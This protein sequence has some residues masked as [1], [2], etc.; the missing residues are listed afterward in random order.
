MKKNIL[1]LFAL[2]VLLLTSLACGATTSIASYME[3]GGISFVSPADQA[4]YFFLDD[5]NIP[6]VPVIIRST[7]DRDKD[8]TIFA[9]GTPYTCI[10][11]ANFDTPCGEVPIV[12]GFTTLSAQ[13][14]K[15]DGKTVVS[16]E[17][18]FNWTPPKGIDLAMVWISNQ[19]GAANPSIGYGLV[20]FIILVLS[21]FVFVKSGNWGILVIPF[22]SLVFIAIYGYQTGSVVITL[23]VLRGIFGAIGSVFVFLCVYR[24][25]NIRR[26]G[27][28]ITRPGGGTARYS[29]SGGAEGAA[30]ITALAEHA[31]KLF[32]D[33]AEPEY[34]PN[35]GVTVTKI[36]AKGIIGYIDAVLHPK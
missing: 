29:G 16:T 18:T 2:A 15:I 13:T 26:H 30:V 11:K 28:L 24:W 19:V 32:G 14:F 21:S 23:Y 12:P 27:L 20:G 10:A 25:I 8:V 33:P 35:S 7:F 5:G 9:Y 3:R 6:P 22:L 34:L 31:D 1:Y 17:T 36:P 4:K